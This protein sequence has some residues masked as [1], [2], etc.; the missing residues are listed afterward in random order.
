M[1]SDCSLDP[2]KLDV[3]GEMLS[4]NKSIKFVDLR[5][6]D[7]TDEGIEKLMHHLMDNNTLQQIDFCS[8]SITTDGM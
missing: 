1:L 3:I 5:D 2:S 6:N 7:I 8:N 4:H